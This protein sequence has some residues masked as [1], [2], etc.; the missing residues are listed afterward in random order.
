MNNTQTVTGRIQNWSTWGN[1][2]VGE[3]YDD[4]EGRFA[5]GTH[6]QTSGLQPLAKQE[7]GVQEGAVV[8]TRN[9][10]YLLGKRS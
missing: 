8:K 9:S 6:I 10:S 2:V 5:D 4:I 1:T 3:I 7:Q